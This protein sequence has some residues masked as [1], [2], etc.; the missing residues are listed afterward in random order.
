[1]SQVGSQLA[2]PS[3]EVLHVRAVVAYDGTDF[4]GFQWQVEGR[5]VQGVLEAALRQV[6]QWD[7]RVIGAGRTDAGVHACGQVIGFW[8][9]WRHPL[10]DLQRALNA[11]LSED[12]AIL[13]V[14]P[15]AEGWHPRFSALRRHYRY[16]VL[17]RPVRD[18]LARRY[19]H[20][21]REPLDLAL[22]Q[23]A[24][25]LIVGE[26]DFASFGRPMQP[27]ETTVRCIYSATWRQEGEWYVLDVTGNAFLR[28]MVRSLVG[29]MLQ[30]GSGAWPVA[31]MA[32]V[33]AA[34]DRALAAPPAPACGLCLMQVDY[35]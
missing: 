35:E 6:T 8:T 33:L 10:A 5:T 1:M 17:N 16:T 9:P 14:A 23:A 4:L 32:E 26:H 25:D 12:V 30:V 11:V 13:D 2:D 18:P 15:A 7:A 24:A 28:G 21:V 19:A 29:A 3:P 27:G 34:R 20:L 31:Q 22:L